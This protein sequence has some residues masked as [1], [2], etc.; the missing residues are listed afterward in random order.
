MT[1]LHS[2]ASFMRTWGAPAGSLQEPAAV[3]VV[4]PT[5]LRPSL[6]RALT[7]VFA[8]DFGGRIHVLIGIDAP[9]GEM[10]MLDATCRVAPPHCIVQALYPGYSTSVRHNGQWAARDGGA[11]RTILSYLANAPLIAYLDDDNWWGPRHLA[12]LARAIDP[13]DWAFSLRWFVH[14]ETAAPVCVDQWESVGPDAGIYR[15]RF[16]GFVDPNCLMIKTEACAAAIPWWTVPLQ[17]DPKGMSA[18]RHVFDYL[19]RHHKSAC[20]GEA[21]AFYVVD[22]ADSM[23]PTRLQLMGDAYRDAGTSAAI[24]SLTQ[25]GRGEPLQ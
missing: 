22:P 19:R 25:T 4:I 10:E 13:V 23:H 14:P 11:L 6:I 12:S 21:S 5:I 18:D 8:Q 20:T 17:G 7:S 9:Q 3:A 15:T 1:A 2:D 24:P 16:N